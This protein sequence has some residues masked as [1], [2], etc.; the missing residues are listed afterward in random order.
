MTNMTQFSTCASPSPVLPGR[1]VLSFFA[2]RHC[3]CFTGESEL[4]P[5]DLL[6]FTAEVPE[7]MEVVT[8]GKTFRLEPIST[9][10]LNAP[11]QARSFLERQMHVHRQDTKKKRLCCQ[12]CLWER[13][14]TACDKHA[15][16]SSC[17]ASCAGNTPGSLNCFCACQQHFCSVRSQRHM[18]SK[19]R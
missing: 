6:E 12:P 11:E 16:T 8:N 13:V 2:V 14:C 15:T 4:E 5:G 7:G 3:M 9:A 1:L 17:V 19:A 10:S 18:R